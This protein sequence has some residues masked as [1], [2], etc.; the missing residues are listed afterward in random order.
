MPRSAL[1]LQARR[2]FGSGLPLGLQIRVGP[3]DGLR[4]VRLPSSSA[5]PQSVGTCP[6][7]TSSISSAEASVVSC[8]GPERSP[9]A[10]PEAWVSVD[11]SDGKDARFTRASKTRDGGLGPYSTV[12]LAK[13][14]AAAERCRH[15]RHSEISA[16]DRSSKLLEQATESLKKLSGCL[17]DSRPAG[18]NEPGGCNVTCGGHGVP[19]ASSLSLTRT[20]QEARR[21]QLSVKRWLSP[22]AYP[23]HRLRRARAGPGPIRTRSGSDHAACSFRL[24]LW[25]VPAPNRRAWPPWQ[26]RG[27]WLTARCALARAMARGTRPSLVGRQD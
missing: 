12:S 11:E 1:R 3:L 24:S 22:G 8:F 4:W 15:A 17:F 2:G 7:R 10:W 5:N 21:P 20:R 9:L 6:R 19:S 16:R 18:P 25:A 13:A 27:L 23:L 14:H 26:C